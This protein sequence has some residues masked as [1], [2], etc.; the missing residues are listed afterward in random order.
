MLI[1][2]KFPSRCAGCGKT[3]DVGAQIEWE[4]GSGARHPECKETL[5]ITTSSR[6][7]PGNVIFT[8]GKYWVVLHQTSAQ[9]SRKIYTAICR[10]ANQSELE[11]FKPKAVAA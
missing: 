8:R 1:K 7:N 9:P 11:M 4:K 2:A 6:P 10:S 5:H 3:I